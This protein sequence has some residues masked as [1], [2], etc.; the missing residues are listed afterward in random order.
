LK[1]DCSNC[2]DHDK[3][4]R[5]CS[6]D[7]STI[8]M[9]HGIKGHATRCPVIDAQ[10]IGDYFQVF[11]YWKKGQYPNNGTWAEQPYRLVRMMESIDEQ[12]A[13][14]NSNISEG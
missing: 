3:E 9:A 5:G 12:T 14:A 13:N 1:Y 10:E 11:K 6:L 8:V 4:V 2:S 7:A